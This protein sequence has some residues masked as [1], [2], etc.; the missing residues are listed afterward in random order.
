MGVSPYL[1]GRFALYF[2][3]YS[4]PN[5]FDSQFADKLNDII[6]VTKDDYSPYL[7]NEMIYDGMFLTQYLKKEDKV[8]QDSEDNQERPKII[9]I[10]PKNPEQ[11]EQMKTNKEQFWEKYPQCN[12]SKHNQNHS[13]YGLPI[14][15]DFPPEYI[16]STILYKDGDHNLEKYYLYCK[17]VDNK[18]YY[19]LD[20]NTGVSPVRPRRVSMC[21][22][23]GVQKGKPHSSQT[24]VIAKIYPKGNRGLKGGSPVIEWWEI[25]IV[26]LTF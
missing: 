16:P 4:K 13:H 25:L 6:I 3:S 9:M 17:K 24:V 26:S 14:I 5:Y 18:Y 20:L 22:K 12:Y 7:Y 23:E 15:N 2:V 10:E 21:E 19:M 11:Y 8:N 1:Y